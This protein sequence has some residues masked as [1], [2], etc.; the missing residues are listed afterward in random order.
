[1]A[2]QLNTSAL[3]A[4]SME[5]K[6]LQDQPVEGFRVKLVNDESLFDWEVAIFVSTI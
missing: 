2:H 5:F 6:G 1:M 3:R 4:L